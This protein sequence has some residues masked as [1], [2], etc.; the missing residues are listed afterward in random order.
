VA[1]VEVP[2]RA[3]NQPGIGAKKGN[4]ATSRAARVLFEAGTAGT[5]GRIGLQAAPVLAAGVPGNQ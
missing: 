4:G 1:V 2:L 3:A 5:A